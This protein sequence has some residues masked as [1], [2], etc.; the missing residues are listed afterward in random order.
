MKKRKI[1]FADLIHNGIIKSIDTFPLGVGLIAAYAI[2]Q[3]NEDVNCNIYKNPS[4]LNE[5]LL[6]KLPDIMCFSNFNWNLNLSIAFAKYIKAINKEIPVIF[7][8]PNLPIS[9]DEREAFLQSYPEI[10]FYIFTN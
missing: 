4:E 7:G 6:Y 1:F 10:D 8:G 9:K 3:Y 2:D 5:A